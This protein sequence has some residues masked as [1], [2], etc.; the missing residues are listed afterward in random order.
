MRVLIAAATLS[1][2]FASPH[3]ALAQE[4]DP[5]EGDD[6]GI[7]QLADRLNDPD[8]Q[9][10]ASAMVHTLGEVLLSLPVGPLLSAAQEATGDHSADV[11]E[12]ATVRDL[13]G[14]E[15][16]DMPRELS[17]RVPQMMG[18]LAG[19]V[20]GLDAMRP[21]LTELSETMREKI[22]ESTMAETGEL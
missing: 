19:L 17:E 2:A 1:L 9:E 15:A 21:A 12:S 13:V 16:Q 20:E 8:Q 14:E 7:A 5:L 3:V 4:A 22:A 11:D 18:L 10:H 6:A